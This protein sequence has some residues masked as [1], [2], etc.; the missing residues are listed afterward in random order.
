MLT[1][2][3]ED[4]LLSYRADE[5]VRD[6]IGAS[7]IGAPCMRAIWYEYNKYEGIPFTAQQLMT[8]EIGKAIEKKVKEKL[9]YDSR[10]IEISELE[11]N[12]QNIKGTPDLIYEPT[13]LALYKIIYNKEKIQAEYIIEIKTANK[14]QFNQF[15]KHGLLQW[16]EQYYAQAQAYMGMTG[17]HKAIIY[18]INKDNSDQH[19]E[20]IDFDEAYYKMLLL[21][22]QSIK[23]SE[24]PPTR[25]SEEPEYFVCSQCKFREF[26]HKD[27]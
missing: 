19:E 11:S 2:I 13:G 16:K 26:C 8:F 3:I 18:C 17:I 20:K 4:K 22:A 12:C 25:I 15:K 9:F 6:Y 14:T 27:P 21:R 1:K 5:P 23:N 10:F 7:A 24:E